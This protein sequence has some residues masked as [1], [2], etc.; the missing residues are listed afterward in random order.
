MAPIAV[1]RQPHHLPGLAIHRQRGGAGE[2]SLGVPTER[3][4]F[5]R[6]RHVL[7]SEQFFGRSLWIVRLGE[8]RQRL[9]L[10]R[11]DGLRGGTRRQ[12]QDQNRPGEN[13]RKHLISLVAPLGGQAGTRNRKDYSAAMAFASRLNLTAKRASRKLNDDKALQQVEPRDAG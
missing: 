12:K 13:L 2:A 6:R 1:A 11:A 8:R 4:R 9:R 7:A 3:A 5:Q 10:K